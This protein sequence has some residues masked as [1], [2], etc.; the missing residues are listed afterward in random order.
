[1]PDQSF[2]FD[3]IKTNT[4]ILNNRYSK[5]NKCISGFNDT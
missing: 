4:K 2:Y 3:K 1:M 5:N